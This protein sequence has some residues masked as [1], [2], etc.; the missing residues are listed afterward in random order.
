MAHLL[1]ALTAV[2]MLWSVASARLS[3][4]LIHAPLLMVAGGAVVGWTS[5]VNIGASLDNNVALHTAELI[6]AI[7]LFGDSTEVRGGPLGRHPRSA[8]RLLFLALPLT[9]VAA[10]LLGRWLF[11]GVSWV[12]LVIVACI[13]APIDFAPAAAVLRDSRVPERVRHVLNVESGYNDGILAPVFAAALAIAAQEP[14]GV[15]PMR[16]LQLAIPSFLGAIGVGLAFGF[17]VGGMSWFARQR[18]WTD[19]QAVRVGLVALPILTFAF[20]VSINVNGFVAAFVCGLAFKA[21]RRGRPDDRELELIDDVSTIAVL[22]LWFAFGAMFVIIFDEAPRVGWQFILFAVLILTLARAVPVLLATVRSPLS[23]QDRTF[24]GFMGPRG[25]TSIVFG[26]LAFNSLGP[27]DGGF[28]VTAM[29]L[30]VL[31]SVVVHGVGAPVL[32][33]AG[34]FPHRRRDQGA[35]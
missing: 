30:T 29:G 15:S 25:A 20:A 22:L 5:S 2:V 33:R 23:L 4:W 21:A 14:T 18:G 27:H 32:V 34:L 8:L 28:V 12:V 10:V 3:A 16:A 17:I 35:N 6:L 26:L 19:H 13:V 24:V 7:L 9:V 11:P 1:V 31:A